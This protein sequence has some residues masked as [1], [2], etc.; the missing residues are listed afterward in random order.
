MELHK[1][2]DLLEMKYR[3]YHCPEFIINDPISIPHKFSGL[4]DIEIAAFWTAILSWGQRPVIISKA[5]ELMQLMDNAP[6]DFVINHQEPDRKRFQSFVHRT[7]QYPDSLCFLDFFQKHYQTNKSLENA[8]LY[9]EMDS[10]NAEMGLTHFHHY[11]FSIAEHMQRS[12][13]HIAN[14]ASNSTCKRINMFLRWMVR[15]DEMGIDFGLWKRIPISELMIP[16]DVHV[17][18]VARQLKLLI[19]KQRD[20]KAVE[21]LTSALRKMDEKDPVRYDYALFGMGVMGV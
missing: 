18:N 10:W 21:E 17:E 3:E 8:F 9:D 14:P 1:I 5:T 13:K 7:F 2:K 16:F 6:F 20:W 15:E 11:F 19:R 12:K 4:Q